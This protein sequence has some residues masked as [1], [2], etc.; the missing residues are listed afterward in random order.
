[1]GTF[2]FLPLALIPLAIILAPYYIEPYSIWDPIHLNDRIEGERQTKW[3]NMGW[4]EKTDSFPVAAKSLAEKLLDFAKE[5]GYQVGGNVLDMGHGAGES[6]LLHLNKT[7]PPRHLHGLTTLESDTRYALYLIDHYQPEKSQSSQIKLFTKSAQYDPTN[8][9]Q[10]DHPLNNMKGF[11][12]EQNQKHYA[13]SDEDEIAVEITDS[14]EP[15]SLGSDDPPPYNLIYILDSIYHYPPS[16]IPFL[17]SVKPVLKQ[18]EG[19]IV[20]TDILPPFKAENSLSIWK[21]WFISYILSVPLKNLNDRPKSLEEYKSLLEGKGW[22]DVKVEDWSD[23]VWKGF[24]NN[25]IK[26]G[27]KWKKVGETVRRVEKDG[28]KFV[29]VRAKKGDN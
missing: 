25:L 28:W 19:I 2:S 12:G 9:K 3:C 7:N 23:N 15:L 6:L 4:W 17:D 20:Y 24:A 29:A 16:L 5:G 10:F 11:M 14:N 21:S 13:Y 1:M 27:G 26:R 22:K 8:S 18:K